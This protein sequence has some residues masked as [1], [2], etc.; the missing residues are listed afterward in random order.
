MT[1]CIQFPEL[2]G[3]ICRCDRTILS[4]FPRCSV[5][6]TI[7]N[8]F[9]HMNVVRCKS[10]SQDSGGFM[11]GGYTDSKRS[12]SGSKNVD[13]RI[14]QQGQRGVQPYQNDEQL[15]ERFLDRNHKLV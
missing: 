9:A 4:C 2:F 10:V 6:K 5:D 8:Y 1:C 3:D 7:D 15:R 13:F 14:E 11:L 12:V